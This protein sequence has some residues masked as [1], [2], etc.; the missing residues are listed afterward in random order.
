MI[1]NEYIVSKNIVVNIVQQMYS[2]IRILQ[3]RCCIIVDVYYNT[4]TDKL[5][6]S[7]VFTLYCMNI[8]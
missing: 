2:N 6:V 4:I 7:Y 3:I 1:S 8:K 5:I